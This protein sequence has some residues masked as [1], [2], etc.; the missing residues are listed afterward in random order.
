MNYVVCKGIVLLWNGDLLLQQA[1]RFR[2]ENSCC[3]FLSYSLK[4][5]VGSEP[6][7]LGYEG[8]WPSRAFLHRAHA[9]SS[10]GQWLKHK[11]E[12]RMPRPSTRRISHIRECMWSAAHFSSD[13]TTG[14]HKSQ[15]GKRPELT[16]P[17]LLC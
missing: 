10:H 11:L 6:A 16:R 7:C 5:A 13:R 3:C 14:K 12:K 15:G 2:W 9:L 17:E 8:R 4:K 1:D